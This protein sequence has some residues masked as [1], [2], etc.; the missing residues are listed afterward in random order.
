MKRLKNLFIIFIFLFLL[1]Q[2]SA[3]ITFKNIDY[4]AQYLEPS[5]TYDLYITIESDKEI[6]NTVVYI[7]PTNQISKE[8]I[9]IIRGKQWIGHLFPYEYGVAHLIIKINPNAPNYDYKITGYCNYTKV[10]SNILKIEFL[11]FQ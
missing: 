4:N 11:P 1:S 5:K 8:N 2:V 7:E 10:I 9:E 3:Y 6:N